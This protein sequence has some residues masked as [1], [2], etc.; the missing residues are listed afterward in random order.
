MEGGVV[1]GVCRQYVR[2]DSDQVGRCPV[3]VSRRGGGGVVVVEV[4]RCGEDS[5]TS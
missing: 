2:W 4:L 3:S 5:G 1:E